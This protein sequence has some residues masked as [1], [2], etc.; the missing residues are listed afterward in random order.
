MAIGLAQTFRSAIPYH[1]SNKRRPKGPR[2]PECIGSTHRNVDLESCLL[3]S[4]EVAPL[5]A[6]AGRICLDLSK[7]YTTNYQSGQQRIASSAPILF[8][9]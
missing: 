7:N 2:Q 9:S 6:G 5:S 4:V 3:A 1:A 8:V